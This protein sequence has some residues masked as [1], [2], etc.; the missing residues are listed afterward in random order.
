MR[1]RRIEL[2]QTSELKSVRA[3]YSQARTQMKSLQAETESVRALRSGE[4]PELR[5]HWHDIELQILSSIIRKLGPPPLPLQLLLSQDPFV[6][7][8]GGTTEPDGLPG[9]TLCCENSAALSDV[10]EVHKLQ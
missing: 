5:K 2:N 10:W 6:M 8:A 1:V 4:P 9:R 3:E 7:C